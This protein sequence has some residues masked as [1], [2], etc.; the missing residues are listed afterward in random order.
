MR[1]TIRHARSLVIQTHHAPCSYATLDD[2]AI[3]IKKSF[4]QILS[5]VSQ[6]LSGGRQQQQQQQQQ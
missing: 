6:N 3:S 5:T 4:M 2:W 1:D